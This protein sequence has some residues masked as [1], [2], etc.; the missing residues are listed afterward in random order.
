LAAAVVAQD[1]PQ[2]SRLTISHQMAL[3]L[4]VGL[5][6]LTVSLDQLFITVVA[7]AVPQIIHSLQVR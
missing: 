5:V 7:V 3:Q 6:L 2:P 4:T 1:R